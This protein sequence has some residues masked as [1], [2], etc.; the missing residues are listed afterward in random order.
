MLCSAFPAGWSLI[1][2]LCAGWPRLL[3]QHPHQ[4]ARHDEP[5]PSKARSSWHQT[6]RPP[7]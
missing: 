6:Y 3:L 5:D 2:S 1:T 7:I 4:G